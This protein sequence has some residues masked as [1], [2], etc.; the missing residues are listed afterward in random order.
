MSLLDE[1]QDIIWTSPSGKSF[2]IKTIESGYTQKHIG[3]VKENPRT[4]ISTKGSSKNKKISVSTSSSVKRVGDSNDTFTDLGI[5]GR[6]VSLDCYFIGTKHYSEANAF[7]KALCEIGKSKLQLAYEEEFTVNVINFSVKNSLVDRI[8]ATIV[9]VNWHE[10]SPSTYPKSEK[11]KQKEIKTLVNKT[12]EEIALTVEETVDSIDNQ[13]R[14]S[15][16][17]NKFENVLNNIS[18]SIDTASDISLNSIMSDILN[19]DLISNAFTITSQI[20]VI[21]SKA[22]NLTNQVKNID[23]SFDL[24]SG[25]SSVFGAWENLI[26]NL[27]TASLKTSSFQEYKKEQIDELKLNDSIASSAIVSVSESLLNTEFETRAE[28]VEAAKKLVELNNDWNDFVDEQSSRITDLGDAYIRNGNVLDVVLS[29]ANEIL[30]RSYKL[31]VE[32]IIT[33]S[34]DTTPIELAWEYYKD[35]FKE[36]PDSTLEYLIRTNNFTDDE[37]F[38]IQRGKEV[39]IY[40]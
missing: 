36:N 30:E 32:Q 29:S 37:F 2:K 17:K 13:S 15:I 34:E 11:S 24:P 33:L 38:L 22:A 28:A 26:S 6:D 25:Y 27:K 23:N 3:E 14:L 40:V 35:D 31:K 21:F 4:S 39:K 19:Q 18:S 10:T 8:N 12:K 7:R 5:G 16:F 9:S 20:G 1:M